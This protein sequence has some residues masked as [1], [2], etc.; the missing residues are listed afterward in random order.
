MSS[1]DFCESPADPDL[2]A[3]LTELANERDAINQRSTTDDGGTIIST[4]D[5][6]RLEAIR[7]E[8]REIRRQPTVRSELQRMGFSEDEID[9]IEKEGRV[10]DDDLKSLTEALD[11][12]LSELNDQTEYDS[13]RVSTLMNKRSQMIQLTSN[14]MRD[15]HE[16]SKS[17]I[18]NI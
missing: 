12:Q 18:Q 1:L 8:I 6:A 2:Q 15:L 14:I 13:M 11:S 10:S 5:Q 17:V 16:T 4:Q 9:S 7:G 3:R